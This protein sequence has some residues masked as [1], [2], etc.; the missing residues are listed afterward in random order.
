MGGQSRDEGEE[1]D[2]GGRTEGTSQT[3]VNIEA[4]PWTGVGQAATGAPALIH[5][6]PS[7]LPSPVSSTFSSASTLYSPAHSP[8][9]ATSTSSHRTFSHALLHTTPHFPSLH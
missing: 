9:A 3:R 1:R 8:P 2:A 4:L 7:S 6:L 5:P